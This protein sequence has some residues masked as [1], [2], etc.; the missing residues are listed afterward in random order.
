[1]EEIADASHQHAEG[2][3]QITRGVHDID[4]VVQRNASSAEE[5]AAAAEDMSFQIS[6]IKETVRRLAPLVG[7]ELAV[8]MHG[9]ARLLEA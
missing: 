3:F 1:V 8:R 4:S 9:D 2:V 7:G 5:F 6:Q